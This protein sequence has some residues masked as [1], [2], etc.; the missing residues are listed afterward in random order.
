V[1]ITEYA[2]TPVRHWLYRFLP[3]RWLL[4]HPEP[5]LPGFWREDVGE[6]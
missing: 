4:V 5:F 3:F 1:L 6:N 2:E